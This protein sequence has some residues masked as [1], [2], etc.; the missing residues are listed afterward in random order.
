MTDSDT[1][2]L[3]LSTS[4]SISISISLPSFPLTPNSHLTEPCA[5]QTSSLPSRSTFVDA[6]V[7]SRKHSYLAS[8]PPSPTRVGEEKRHPHTPSFPVLNATH[9]HTHKRTVASGFVL[10]RVKDS[11]LSTE[12]T[13]YLDIELDLSSVASSFVAIVGF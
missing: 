1:L 3:Y 8:L 5:G 10:K 13:W 12:L 6:T 7:R 9:D 2:H 4:L 11:P